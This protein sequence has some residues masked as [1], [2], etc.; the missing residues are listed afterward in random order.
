[1]TGRQEET[2]QNLKSLAWLLII[3][4]ALTRTINAL[5]YR[6]GLGF[7]SVENVQYIEMLMHSW[8]LPAP[9]AAWATSHPPS[10]L[11]PVCCAGARA[12]THWGSPD[13]FLIAI[14]LG[15]RT[16]RDS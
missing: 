2:G 12:S 1:M 16:S 8:V 9:D 6:T 3:T 10:L 13:S 7:D 15:R 14:P 4:A 5:G 11:L